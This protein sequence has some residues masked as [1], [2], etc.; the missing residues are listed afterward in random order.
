MCTEIVSLTELASRINAAHDACLSS[1][2]DAVTRAI[3]VG[4]LLTEAKDKVEHGGWVEANC[5]FGIREAQRYMRVFRQ[6]DR[7]EEEM[8]HGVSHL[9]SLRDLVVML[10]CPREMDD[11]LQADSERP[12]ESRPWTAFDGLEHVQKAMLRIAERWPA[13]ELHVLGARLISMGHEILERGELH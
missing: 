13:G 3:E 5:S 11:L 10:T 4:R 6:R 1:A 8:R 2:Q 9:G 7:I 12:P